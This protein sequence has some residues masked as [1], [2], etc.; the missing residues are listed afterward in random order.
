MPELMAAIEKT[1][2]LASIWF[3]AASPALPDDPP[4]RHQDLLN[5]LCD[6]TSEEGGRGDAAPH[7]GRHGAH[8]R[9][10]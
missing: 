2:A 8:A 5:A 4:R 7:R 6:R 3:C 1:N 10:R 9:G